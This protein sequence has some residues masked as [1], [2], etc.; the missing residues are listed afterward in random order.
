AQ[1]GVTIAIENCGPFH[2]GIDQTA[3]DLAT[4]VRSL[5]QHGKVCLDTGHAAVNKNAAEL[6]A[7]L[8][9]VIAHFHVHDNHGA[10]D[11]H[12]PIGAGSIDFAPYVPILERL[13]G[14]AIAEIV[15]EDAR[16]AQ[17]PEA[18]ARATK[19]GWSRL[20]GKSR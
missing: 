18:L 16:S 1:L 20:L 6:V 13:D 2:A 9:D 5:G 4:I 14:M 8:G 10:R 11:E 7:S 15:W 3:G 19:D 17:P 12:L